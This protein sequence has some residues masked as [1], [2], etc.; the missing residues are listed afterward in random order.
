MIMSLNVFIHPDPLTLSKTPFPLLKPEI[1]NLGRV[2]CH[3]TR[4]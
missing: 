4:F 2:G 1:G 3:K